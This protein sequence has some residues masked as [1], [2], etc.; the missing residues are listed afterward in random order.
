[1]VMAFS[2]TAMQDLKEQP[3]APSLE[4]ILQ[5]FAARIA[6]HRLLDSKVQLKIFSG[7]YCAMWVFALAFSNFH[8]CNL[9][10]I[11]WTTFHPRMRFQRC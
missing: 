1:M 6:H 10:V 3:A 11:F 8:Q 2:S 9:T 4:F 5:T 7:I